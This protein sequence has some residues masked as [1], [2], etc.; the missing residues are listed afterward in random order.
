MKNLA[1]LIA[2]VAHRLPEIWIRTWEH[3]MLTSFSTMLAMAMGVPLGI[4]VLKKGRFRGL[5]LGAVGVLQTIPSLAMLAFLLA[6]LNKI[7]ALP[8]LVA[9]TL[10]ALLPIVRNTLAGLEGVSG[11]VMEAAKAWA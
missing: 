4:L 2:Y 5:V 6:L 11:E 8:A 10:Y 1:I 7:G 3:L 9:L